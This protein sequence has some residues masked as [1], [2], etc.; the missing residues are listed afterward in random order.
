MEIPSLTGIDK[1]RRLLRG[2]LELGEKNEI[3]LLSH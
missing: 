2:R 1:S 3:N